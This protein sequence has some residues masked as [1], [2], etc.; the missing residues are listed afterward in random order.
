MCG[1]H[2]NFFCEGSKQ[3]GNKNPHCIQHLIIRFVDV[4]L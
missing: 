3:G 2:S 4:V 1:A